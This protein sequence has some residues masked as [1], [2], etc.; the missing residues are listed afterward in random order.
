MGSGIENKE[1]R[2]TSEF[3]TQCQMRKIGKTKTVLH[4]TKKVRWIPEETVI[5]SQT[6]RKRKKGTR[7]TPHWFPDKIKYRK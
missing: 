6:D 3:Q 7:Q 5:I 2:E 1:I 4:Y